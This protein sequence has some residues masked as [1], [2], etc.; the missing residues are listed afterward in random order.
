MV[1]NLDKLSKCKKDPITYIELEQVIN[2]NRVNFLADVLMFV[3]FVILVLWYSYNTL[4]LGMNKFAMNKF[5]ETYQREEA[6]KSG[7]NEYDTYENLNKQISHLTSTGKYLMT[8]FTCFIIADFFR[9]SANTYEPILKDK[10]TNV[11]KRIVYI[12]TLRVVAG[13]LA[14]PILY[15]FIELVNKSI[16]YYKSLGYSFKGTGTFWYISILGLYDIATFKQTR[17]NIEDFVLPSKSMRNADF[18]KN[19]YNELA[20]KV[21]T[22]TLILF[23]MYLVALV[24]LLIISLYKK[25]PKIIKRFTSLMNGNVVW[26]LLQFYILEALRYP[27]KNI[28]NT[29]N[30]RATIS[31]NS[32][33]D[34]VL[35]ISK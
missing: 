7:S 23:C 21:F 34:T 27:I 28:M 31:V 17:G 8:M 12:N 11:T 30:N 2:L 20:G 29:N 15:A 6:Y 3:I 9:R 14:I 18:L 35:T 26:L 33:G 24:V 13:L 4:A 25:D 22:P 32:D 16:K 19:F 5:V 1:N 10:C